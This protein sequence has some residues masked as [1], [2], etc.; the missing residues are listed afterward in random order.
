VAAKITGYPTSEPVAPLKG[1]NAGNVV[2]DKSQGESSTAA[3]PTSQTGDHV[4]L[5]D[6][7]RSLQKLSDAIAQTPVVNAS[8]VATIKQAVQ[9]GTYQVNPASVADKLLQF[10]SG[11]K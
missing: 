6:S 7:A 2:T 9:S 11:L 10:E 8:K 5:T 1:S 3:A 4:T